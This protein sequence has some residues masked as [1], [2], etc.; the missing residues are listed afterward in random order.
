MREENLNLRATFLTQIKWMDGT[1]TPAERWCG[2]GI[3]AVPGP[4]A[5]PDLYLERHTRPR[6][7]FRPRA[8]LRSLS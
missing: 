7:L 5:R 3:L 6:R 1:I 4:R 8:C 2:V